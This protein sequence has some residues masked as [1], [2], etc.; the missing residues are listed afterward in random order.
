MASKQSFV[1]DDAIR[2]ELRKRMSEERFATYLDAESGDEIAACQKY[3][4]NTAVASAFYGPIQTLEV[5][6]RN[7]THQAIA[8][9]YGQQWFKNTTLLRYPEAE[10]SRLAIENLRKRDEQATPGKVIA[11]LGLRFWVSLFSRH[12]DETLWRFQLFKVFSPRLDR[13]AAHDDLDRLRTLRN[14]IAHHEPIFQR[15]LN[16]DYR[17]LQT[18][19][20]AMSPATWAWVDHH[21]RVLGA[22]GTKATDV[23]HF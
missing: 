2:A 21:S 8:N 4:W 10:L 9:S 11:E 23:L 1:Y 19:T 13:S 16:D 6:L 20:M 14:R 18:M 3:V 15:R 12:Y 22:L 17:R 5:T 7:A